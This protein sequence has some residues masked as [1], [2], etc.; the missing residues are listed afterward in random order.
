LPELPATIVWAL[1]ASGAREVARI[2]RTGIDGR[3]TSVLARRSD[4]RALG[5][6]VDGQ[7][8]DQG[9]VTRWVESVDLE[10]GALGQPEPLAPTE[11]SDRP[12]TLCS[13]DD[14]GW[15]VD[16]PFSGQVSLKVGAVWEAQAQSSNVRL[17]LSRGRACV[18]HVF[19]TF[20]QYGGTAPEMLTKSPRL[21]ARPDARTVEVSLLSSNMRYPLRCVQR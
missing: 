17:R 7:P 4:G 20:Q 18:E 14:A 8:D 5:V 11:L 13:G 15:V 19:G 16:L 12:V 6:V 21:P 3:P 9:F 2:P 1:D 10:T